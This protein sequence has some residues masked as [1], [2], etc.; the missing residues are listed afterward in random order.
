MPPKEIE[1]LLHLDER[2]RCYPASIACSYLARR[3]GRACRARRR[4]TR[5][6]TDDDALQRRVDADQH[7]ARLQRLHDQRAEHGA[8]DGADAA[9]ERGAAD[10][11]RGDDVELVERAQ[12]VGRRVEAGRCE[13]A[14]AMPQSTPISTKIFIV[15]QRVLMPA[16]SAASGLPPMAKT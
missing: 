15:T 1:M 16:S 11:R 2:R 10:D 14:A 12:R 9:G 4:T 13:M 6:Q 7:H 5:T 3:C 8:G